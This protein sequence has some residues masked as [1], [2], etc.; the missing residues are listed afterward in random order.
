MRTE[1]EMYD[2]I[3][4]FAEKDDRIR[5]VG[6]EGSRTNPNVP[7]DIFQD[8]DIS[9]FVTDMESF[10]SDDKWLD[11]F[12]ERIIMQKPE[13]MSLFPPELGN[14]FSYLMLFTDGNRIDLKLIPLAETDLYLEGDKLVKILMD[15]DGLFPALPDPTDI[16]YHVKRPS[17]ENFTDNCSEFWWVS[18][19]VA[20]GLWRKEILYAN[21]H[22]N[23]HVRPAL[24]R[25]LE[26]KAGILTNFSKS[27]GK[28]YKYLSQFI[29]EWEWQELLKTYKNSNYDDCWQSLFTMTKLFRNVSIYVSEKLGYTY[30]EDDDLRVTQY[31]EKVYEDSKAP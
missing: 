2:L 24:L 8:F 22:I 14:W 26:W 12:G 31:L 6:M 21:A 3:L 9:Y 7:R 18:T 5:A 19:Y 11:V 20:K 10:K 4:A 25:S 29:S 28:Q 16:D 27:V 23:G 1:K 17:R 15:K 30:P 13:I